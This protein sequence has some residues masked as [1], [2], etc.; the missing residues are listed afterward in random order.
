[1]F[2]EPRN[3]LRSEHA[4]KIDAP[5]GDEQ[6]AH[7]AKES[8]KE[9]FKQELRDNSPTAS[10]EGSSNC[11]LSP[12]SRGPSEQEIGDIC[13]G[14]EENEKHR[15]KDGNKRRP[16]VSHDVF[17]QADNQIGSI[18]I[19]LRILCRQPR[20]NRVQFG[21]ALLNADSRFQTPDEAEE[22]TVTPLDLLW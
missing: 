3:V 8:E 15:G 19:R 6:A 16:D 13:A 5:P 20:S 11:N 7:G 22:M 17:V 21:I 1:N 12:A 2:A 18:A 4:E 14:N 9:A 10:G